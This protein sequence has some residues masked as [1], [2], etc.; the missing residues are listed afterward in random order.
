[1]EV[2]QSNQEPR[3]TKSTKKVKGNATQPTNEEDPFEKRVGDLARQCA[4]MNLLF[5]EKAHFIPKPEGISLTD[6]SVLDTEEGVE[7]RITVILYHITPEDLTKHIVKNPRFKES[8]STLPVVCMSSLVLT[9]RNVVHY[10]VQF[11]ASF[12]GQ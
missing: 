12:I 4:L 8:V 9:R 7:K 3:A 11:R 6:P 1:M 2:E 5:L 10:S